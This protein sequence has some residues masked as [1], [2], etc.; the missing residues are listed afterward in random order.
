MWLINEIRVLSQAMGQFTL[1]VL[2]NKACFK[3]RILHVL[4]TIL[5]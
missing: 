1:F 2:K 4:N 5:I 3:R